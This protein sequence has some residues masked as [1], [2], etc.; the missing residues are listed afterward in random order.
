[1]FFFGFARAIA[2]KGLLAARRLLSGLNVI[3]AVRPNRT[4]LLQV[5][6]TFASLE[7]S[8]DLK[9]GVALFCSSRGAGDEFGFLPVSP[10]M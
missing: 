5:S 4:L 2:L 3:A 7:R 9:M 8:V 10:E 6:R 1:M